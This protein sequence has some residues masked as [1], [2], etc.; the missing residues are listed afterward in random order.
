MD[1]KIM[2]KDLFAIYDSL[3]EEQKQHVKECKTMDELYAFAAKEKIELPDEILDSVSGG[4]VFI[5]QYMGGQDY[6]V[7]NDKTGEVMERNIPHYTAADNRAR[8]L[9]QSSQIIGWEELNKLRKSNNNS[10]SSC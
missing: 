7:I 9:G 10:S 3:S 2:D 1:K 6:Q 4:Y 8:T 5:D